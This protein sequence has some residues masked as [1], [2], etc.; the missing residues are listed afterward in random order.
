[1]RVFAY[2][3]LN[4]KGVVWSIRSEKT[5]LVVSRVEKAYFKNA[6]LKVSPAG[7]ARVLK[8]KRKNVHAGVLGVILKNPPRNKEWVRVSYN[9]YISG[10]FTD[11]SGNAILNVKYAK[12]T[13]SGLFVV[14]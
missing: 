13:P 4:R 7:R 11:Q 3:N 5:K 1:M 2:R 12:L 9:P 8:E 10:Y 14:L 6:T